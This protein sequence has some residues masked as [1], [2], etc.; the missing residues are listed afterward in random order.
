MFN[1]HSMAYRYSV[2]IVDN[3]FYKEF[4]CPVCQFKI[5]GREGLI[6]TRSMRVDNRA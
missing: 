5:F 3:A 4:G 6:S 2:C 1:H